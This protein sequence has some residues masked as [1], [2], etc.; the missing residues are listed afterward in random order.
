MVIGEPGQ[1]WKEDQKVRP[2]EHPKTIG[3]TH[4]ATWGDAIKYD[5]TYVRLKWQN[6]QVM[7]KWQKNQQNEGFHELHCKHGNSINKTDQP[8]GGKLFQS[9]VFDEMGGNLKPTGAVLA[10]DYQF[11]RI[12]FFETI[13]ILAVVEF[14]GHTQTGISTISV[15]D[16]NM[17]SK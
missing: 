4:W 8:Q 16:K 15:C 5:Q 7:C 6:L 2:L 17:S 3:Q 12:Q 11:S 13:Q 14:L 1:V 9:C 10:G